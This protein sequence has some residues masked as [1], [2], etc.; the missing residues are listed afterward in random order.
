MK[1]ITVISSD[2]HTG[3]YPRSSVNGCVSD[4]SVTRWSSLTPVRA[5]QRNEWH[6]PGAAGTPFHSPMDGVDTVDSAGALDTDTHSSI[7]I[8]LMGVCHKYH[9]DTGCI[10]VAVS[11]PCINRVSQIQWAWYN[12][13]FHSPM[14]KVDTMSKVTPVRALQKNEWVGIANSRLVLPMCEK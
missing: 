1:T 10:I 8:L 9:G 4:C 13:S 2:T 14:D 12:L 5:S 7:R 6:A 3:P 11:L